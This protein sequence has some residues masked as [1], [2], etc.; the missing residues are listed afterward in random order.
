MT[1]N[2]AVV[3]SQTRDGDN[4][5]SVHEVMFSLNVGFIGVILV[6]RYA[7]DSVVF[8]LYRMDSS[9]RTFL[10]FRQTDLASN[11]FVFFILALALAFCMWEFLRLSSGTRLTKEILL[12][13]V[14]G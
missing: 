7:P 2:R 10:Q 1:E 8:W 3:S 11:Y 14:A 5:K 12:L 13:P 9:I 4:L 6:F